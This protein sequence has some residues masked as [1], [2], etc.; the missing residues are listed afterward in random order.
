LMEKYGLNY[1]SIV[2]S[3]IKVIERKNNWKKLLIYFSLSH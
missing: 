2:E 3:S 1:K